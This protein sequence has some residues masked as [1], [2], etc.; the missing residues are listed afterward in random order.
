MDKL[1]SILH[2]SM[3]CAGFLLY[4]YVETQHAGQMAGTRAL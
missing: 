4:E 1:D 3:T 2:P